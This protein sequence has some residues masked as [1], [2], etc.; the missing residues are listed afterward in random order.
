MTLPSFSLFCF[1]ALSI[2]ESKGAGQ[3]GFCVLGCGEGN[4]GWIACDA[5]DAVGSKGG[6]PVWEEGMSAKMSELR[7][8]RL[9]EAFGL[10][11]R[12]DSDASNSISVLNSCDGLLIWNLRSIRRLKR[13]FRYLI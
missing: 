7:D 3:F 8:G 6:T 1:S 5:L 13:L 12:A 10:F 2:G 4:C 11:D 9:G